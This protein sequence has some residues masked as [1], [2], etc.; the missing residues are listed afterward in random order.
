MLSE[1]GMPSSVR[2]RNS[3]SRLNP[4]RD[5]RTGHPSARRAEPN[6]GLKT[7]VQHRKKPRK[8]PRTR[9]TDLKARFG[10]IV[11]IKRNIK[12]G[13]VGRTAWNPIQTTSKPPHGPIPLRMRS[14]KMIDLLIE[15]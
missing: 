10:I 8:A 9:G 4:S 13:R 12:G 1:P 14:G 3:V 7:G 6:M 11:V 15:Q 2:E 5:S